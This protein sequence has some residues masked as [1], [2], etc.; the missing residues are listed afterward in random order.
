[1]TMES[2]TDTDIFLAYLEQVLCPRLRP[3]QVVV[4]H[5]L[6]AHQHTPLCGR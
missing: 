4:M 5:N 2:P 6:S 3:G 1:M